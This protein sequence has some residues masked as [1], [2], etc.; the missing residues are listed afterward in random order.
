MS[1]SGQEQ[2]GLPRAAPRR[3]ERF[4][5]HAATNVRGSG[6]YDVVVFDTEQE[7]RQ[8]MYVFFSFRFAPSLPRCGTGTSSLITRIHTLRSQTRQHLDPLEGNTNRRYAVRPWV[9]HSLVDDDRGSA[10]TGFLVEIYLL[11]LPQR[12]TW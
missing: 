8:Y 6:T 7:A 12:R 9:H 2:L 10:A 4:L 1:Y 11:P 5:G 3:G